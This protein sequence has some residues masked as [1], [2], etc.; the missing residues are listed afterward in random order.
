MLNDFYLSLES[1][2]P[3]QDVS[4]QDCIKHLAFND[5]GLIPVITQCQESK[6]VLMHAWMN[7]AALEKTLATGRMTYWSRSRNT[8]WIKGETS[9]NIQQ[10]VTMRFDCDGDTILCLVKQIGAACHTGRPNCFYLQINKT[11]NTVK[12]HEPTNSLA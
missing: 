11:S 6:E 7:L 9:G 3:E 5:L 12:L 1:I 8:F 10:L 4:L 2:T